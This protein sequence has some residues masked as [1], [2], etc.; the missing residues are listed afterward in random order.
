MTVVATTHAVRSENGDVNVTHSGGYVTIK[1]YCGESRTF[2]PTALKGALSH[3]KELN[4][5]ADAE[6]RIFDVYGKSID[7]RLDF[8]EVLFVE[9][10]GGR[11]V[12][13]R[14]L[15]NAVK[16]AVKAG[17]ASER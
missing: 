17:K 5:Y 1:W 12:D 6:M 4:D 15:K 10:D 16:A 13:F 11:G 3:V 14:E 9:G 8:D 2:T 7:V